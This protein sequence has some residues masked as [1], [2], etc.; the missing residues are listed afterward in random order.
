MASRYELWKFHT[1]GGMS[2]FKICS[3]MEAYWQHV[4]YDLEA[5]WKDILKFEEKVYDKPLGAE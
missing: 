1:K 5:A 2:G 3:S 4:I